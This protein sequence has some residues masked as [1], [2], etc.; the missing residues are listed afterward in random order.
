VAACAIGGA[1]ILAHALLTLDAD[2]PGMFIELIVLALAT[3]A[4]K[5]PLPL[6]RSG[7]TLSLG[8]PIT[9]TSLLLLDTGQATLIGMA[10]AWSQCTF[11]VRARNPIHKTL[12]SIAAV[13]AS[14]QC[15]GLVFSLVRGDH[16]DYMTG[17]LR[18]LAAATTAYF[19]VNTVLVAGAVSLV[20]R[21]RLGKIWFGDFLLSAPSY[22]VSAGAAAI[23]AIVAEHG[24]YTWGA[25]LVVPLFLTYQS[26]RAFLHRL[27]TE[28]AQVEQLSHVQI[29]TIEALALAIEVKDGTS[30]DHIERLQV[31]AEGLARSLGLPA[32]EVRG[33]RTAA[34]L[35]DIGNL[36]V[37]EHILTKP[38]PL[39]AEEFQRIKIH[40]RVGADILQS[41]P[42][43]YPV[44]S[45]ILSHHEHWDGSG[46]PAGLAGE[47]IPLA[48]RVL[49]VVDSFCAL[50]VDRPYRPARSPGEAI[51]LL[52]SEAGRKLDPGLV[53]RFVA[54]L[55]SLEQKLAHLDGRSAR[56]PAAAEHAQ[57]HT[58]ALEDIAGAHREAQALYDIAQALGSSLGV[59]ETVTRIE[60][61]L[62][63]LL[64]VA[65]CALYVRE[66]HTG[67]FRCQ[68]A[69]GSAGKL[70][71][72][73]TAT[74]VAGL[75]PS[76]LE[77][78]DGGPGRAP[79]SSLVAELAPGGQTLGALAIYHGEESVYTDE[80]RRLFELIAARA[81]P[82][83]Y[84]AMVFEETQRAS[85][86]DPLTGLLN[87]RG[88]RD[89][90]EA[91][92][93]H[94]LA[95]GRSA[96]LLLMDLDGFKSLNDTYG[97]QTGDLAIQHV[98][99]ALRS[100]L[101]SYDMCAR[102][103]GDEFVIV[104][105]DCLPSE[106]EVRR[107]DIGVAVSATPF[108]V[109]PGEFICLRA[110]VGASVAPADGS[111]LETLIAVADQRMYGEKAAR[112]AG[113]LAARTTAGAHAEDPGREAVLGP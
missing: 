80:H 55:P 47:Q 49:S 23:A 91:S 97:H 103:A 35:H 44:A 102:F 21:E 106:I 68:V 15:A 86:T 37:P 18:P 83:L 9:L 95:Q 4:V 54:L 69:L 104:F 22:F 6:A 73:Q 27:R 101:R 107:I 63:D 42:F 51:E 31:Y 1:A 12:F 77:T 74:T 34:L 45:L 110:S 29:A 30:R 72:R 85:L 41:V 112:K 64:P 5:L 56:A 52:E 66:E 78:A 75:T 82:A 53:S 67:I 50:L 84:S 76:T 65:A 100:R 7:S 58:T 70:L 48:A 38:G 108:E 11:R 109:R 40:P 81:A 17:L 99:A 10:S 19:F 105:W 79:G 89:H 92:L 59:R 13:G 87:R 33:L 90:V 96:A 32:E 111:T 25:L 113:R 46:Y 3:S 61:K 62:R 93:A 26:Y 39:S 14:V 57:P 36:A 16:A 24:Q 28:Q 88:M 98:A 8:Y 71:H 94:A 20:A 43:P 60:S 2:R